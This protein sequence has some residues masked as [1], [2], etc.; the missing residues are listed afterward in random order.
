LAVA[1]VANVDNSTDQ[2][3]ASGR[4]RT[5][6]RPAGRDDLQ[7]TLA[8]IATWGTIVA[9]VG[10]GGD[11]ALNDDWAYAYTARHFLESGHIR[12]LDWA[13]P[14][15]VTHALWGAALLR[16]L[17]DSYV[18]LRIGTLVW[19]LFAILLTYAVARRATLAPRP[20]LIVALSLAVSPWFVNLAFTYMT[21]V[22]WLTMM[23]G[24]LVVFSLAIDPASVGLRRA[25]LLLLSG[26]I[27]GAASLTRQFA[28][29]TAPGFAAA[30]ALD[31][32][33]RDGDAW[34]RPTAR[35]TLLFGLPITLLFG[36]FY[37]WYTRIHGSTLAGR[38][39]F[40]AILDLGPG[41]ILTHVF[42]VAHYAGLWVFPL[43]WVVL[44][45][46]ELRL[47]VSRRQALGA[48]LLA[49]GFAIIM[50]VLDL[51]DPA[52]ARPACVIHGLMPYLSNLFF[53]TGL[54]PPTIADVYDG[55]A[56]LPHAGRWLGILLTLGSTLGTVVGTGFATT[57]VRRLRRSV[58]RKDL[59]DATRSE[60][61][62]ETMHVLLFAVGACYLLWHLCTGQF[63][64][65]RYL[66]P[67]LPLVVLFALEA[68]PPQVA[69]SPWILVFLLASGVFSVA[70]T[71]EYLSWNDARD[72]A[73]HG[74]LNQGIS[75]TE[76]DG[77]FE[78]NGPW[79]FE[80]FVRRTGK[81]H[82]EGDGLFW[83]AHAL[84]RVS[85]WPSRRPDCT[86]LSRYPYWTWPG[87][88][89]PAIYVLA[90]APQ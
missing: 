68:A 86:T 59:A 55:R 80:D 75:H 7:A 25:G 27:V 56:P 64:F 83:V 78:V 35:N 48:L 90:C 45:R 44:L 43:A 82:G 30:L 23:L 16:I 51:G 46:R 33:R 26:A 54:G 13:A 67:L 11:F 57:T 58:R 49:G 81:L 29:I 89:D 3:V 70:G 15:L 73:V 42:C 36:S 65:D 60:T 34:L 85:F 8:L 76:I 17:G 22:P 50:F 61:Q 72:R 12:I 79:N 84:Y 38:N 6:S 5:A 71:H 47:V 10:I 2:R 69:G 37:L 20:A 14:S 1:I 62:R 53:L 52:M 28:I 21:D 41:R 88:G 63:L 77:G 18:S 39:T 66:L 32:R 24:A 87:G 19:A 31:H 9:F 4:S 40:H 74:L